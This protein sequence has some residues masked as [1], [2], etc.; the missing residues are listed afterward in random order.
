METREERLKRLEEERQARLNPTQTLP[1][2]EKPNVFQ[3]R[4]LALD[5]DKLNKNQRTSLKGAATEVARGESKLEAMGKDVPHIVDDSKGILGETLDLVGGGS[6]MLGGPYAELIRAAGKAK[7]GEDVDLMSTIS[8]IGSR[9]K[10]GVERAIPAM[11]NDEAIELAQLPDIVGEE[12]GLHPARIASA[13]IPFLKN[14]DDLANYV[15]GKEPTNDTSNAGGPV[16]EFATAMLAEVALDLFSFGEIKVIDKAFSGVRKAVSP[17]FDAVVGA[18]NKVVNTIR[19][20]FSP[21]GNLRQSERKGDVAEGATDKF[22]AEV[23]KTVAVADQELEAIQAKVIE[24][25][26][27]LNAEEL[28]AMGAFFRDKDALKKAVSKISNA[29]PSRAQEIEARTEAFGELFT[30]WFSAEEKAGALS[31]TQFVDEYI[32]GSGPVTR[33]GEKRSDDIIDALGVQKRDITPQARKVRGDAEIQQKFQK[34]RT[35]DDAVERLQNGLPTELDISM[36]AG[37]RGLL[38]N[39]SVATKRLL[40][41]VIK[42]PAFGA[43]KIVDDI[44]I[45]KEGFKPFR[46]DEDGAGWLLPNDIVEELN[47]LQGVFKEGGTVE[48]LGRAYDKIL[49]PWKG[50]KLLSF[51]YHTR[52]AYSNAFQN[53]LADVGVDA[54]ADAMRLLTSK[55]LKG[56]DAEMLQEAKDLGVFGG[57]LYANEYLGRIEDQVRKNIRRGLKDADEADFAKAIDDVGAIDPLTEKALYVAQRAGKEVSREEV[58]EKIAQISK[59]TYKDGNKFS[60]VFG[61]DGHVLRF[62]RL[63]GTG[64]ENGFRLAH[65]IEKRKGGMS[66]EDAMLSVKKYLFDYGELTDF[67]R[68]VMK[69]IIPFYTWSRKNIP[70]MIDA[71]SREPS[72][73]NSVGRVVRA[74]EAPFDDDPLK[75]DYFTENIP[76][77][78]P[79]GSEDDPLYAVADLPIND[80]SLDAFKGVLGSNPVASIVGNS[81]GLDIRNL[82]FDGAGFQPR[83][84][85]SKPDKDVLALLERFGIEKTPLADIASNPKLISYAKTLSPSVLNQLANIAVSGASRGDTG[86]RALNAIGLPRLTK[87]NQSREA[88]SKIYAQREALRQLLQQPTNQ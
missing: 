85:S 18:D 64:I 48:E 77:R 55:S 24:L 59:N 63:V 8:S 86:I 70:L 19:D 81:L 38:H 27:G 50:Y 82:K 32:F 21:F 17:A 52:N 33:T 10:A 49:N 30:E 4:R 29:D 13:V 69:R 71:L 68:K 37:K 84:L 35:F 39:R 25:S 3:L 9:F 44:P 73:F 34:E 75:P 76:I 53:H 58:D 5:S 14:A 42:D 87:V 36:L 65:Y 45:A 20:K 51:G 31:P 80:L 67:E 54:H 56:S 12:F 61:N 41:I 62:N 7:R 43:E 15:S 60:D 26:A 88:G 40:D 66:A 47:K 78:L 74:S 22:R 6:P 2:D 11:D 57:G 1:K 16:S 79:V 23:S 46:L 72:K 28:V 83:E